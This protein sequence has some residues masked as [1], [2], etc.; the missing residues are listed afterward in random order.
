MA[1]YID[2]MKAKYRSMVMSHMIADNKKELLDMASKIG[3]NHKWIQ[4]KSGDIWPAH[5]DICESKIK[6]AIGHGAKRI[7]KRE[8]GLIIN[9]MIKENRLK[10]EKRC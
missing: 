9:K 5:F 8:L 7:T 2:D 10:K 6:L 4:E 1:V 3:V